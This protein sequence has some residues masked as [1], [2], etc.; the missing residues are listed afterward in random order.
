MTKNFYKII[1]STML[2]A[3][4]LI[5]VACNESDSVSTTIVNSD[6]FVVNSNPQWKN[7]P[8]SAFIGSLEGE[9]A[10][11]K[12]VLN[13]RFPNKAA[14]SDAEIAFVSPNEAVA[15]GE[16]LA[17]FYNRG[18]LLVVMRPTSS[19]YGTL[20]DEV[21][22]EDFTDNEAYDELFFAF[23]NKEQ[24]Y[25]MI[26]EPESDEKGN[27]VEVDKEQM[28]QS[29]EYGKT[30]PLEKQLLPVYDADN[31]IEQNVNYWQIRITPFI[32]WI[33]EMGGIQ[34]AKVF[35]RVGD[36]P[37][38]AKLKADINND[39]Q[40]F[41]TNF[42]FSMNNKITSGV[43]EDWYL[44]KNS[45]VS[46]RYTVYPVYM[47]SCNGA[48][49]GDYYIVTGKVTPHND[50]MWGSYEE[51]GGLF[52]MGRCR[53]FGY[54]FDEMNVAFD[55]L[56][57]NNMVDGLRYQQTPIPE[58]ENSSV[59]YSNGFHANISGSV[60][61]GWSKEQGAH[62][63]GSVGFEVGWESKT[64]YSLKT[65]AYSRDS[66][67]PTVKYKYYSNNVKLTDNGIG[68]YSENFPAACR[69]EF[70]AN[71]VWVWHVPAG[72]AGV[73]D[74]STKGFSIRAKVKL[75]YSSWYHWR[76]AVQYDSNRANYSTSEFSYTMNLKSPNRQTWGIIAIKNASRDY[77]LRNIR[78]Y[79]NNEVNGSPVGTIATSYEYNETGSATMKEG[80]YSL[81]FEYC[82]P[83]QNNKLISRGRIDNIVVR[84]G[85]TAAEATTSLSSADA[86]IQPVN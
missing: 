77:T 45:S 17:D 56:D 12:E 46:V 31:D 23:N 86:A 76:G 25:T 29:H 10:D 6:G 50:A 58:N 52:S 62:I 18:G 40:V 22:D 42:P 35:S 71:N 13:N 2:I 66:S 14:I 60:S 80:T 7:C 20:P 32:D 75:Q 44:N 26:A 55:L 57:G 53:M 59:D 63:E 54:W 30:H 43:S 16:Q 65:I 82:N 19:N 33:E 51:A 4:M 84:T 15:M 72:K 9:D 8:K 64:S 78:I 61:G 67:T 34:Q 3:M 39:G 24:H 48:N 74:N 79:K 36:V 1:G 73:K 81:T 38:Y 5:P 41:E 49:A 85:K 47:L 69:T 11:F 27:T 21:E 70:D 68:N 28:I 37:D 83:D